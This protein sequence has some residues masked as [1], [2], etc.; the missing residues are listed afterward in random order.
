[1]EN[2]QRWRSRAS[3][4]PCKKRHKNNEALKQKATDGGPHQVGDLPAS[5]WD[6]KNMGFGLVIT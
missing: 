6:E 4:A 3:K 2:K 5:L 1:M